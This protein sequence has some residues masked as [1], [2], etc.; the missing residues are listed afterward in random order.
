[1][2]RILPFPIKRVLIRIF[3]LIRSG[4][5]AQNALPKKTTCN[6]LGFCFDLERIFPDAQ[7]ALLMKIV[8]NLGF[9]F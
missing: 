4:F 1:M 8:C 7:S 2:T 9:L 5:D 3:V 6:V